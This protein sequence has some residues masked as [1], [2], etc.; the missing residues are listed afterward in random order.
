[1]WGRRAK[2]GNY[3]VVVYALRAAM[4][5]ILFLGR[6]ADRERQTHPVAGAFSQ[7]PVGRVAPTPSA[8]V[9]EIGDISKNF[10]THRFTP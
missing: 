10:F 8:P 2:D 1:M 5:W 6:L 4:D 9:V 3:K 7:G